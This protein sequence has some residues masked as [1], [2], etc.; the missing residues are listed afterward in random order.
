MKKIRISV[1][2]LAALLLCN[3][4]VTA[5]T[6]KMKPLETAA[7]AYFAD[8]PSSRVVPSAT[9]FKAI[10]AKEKLFLLDIRSA[11]D[12]AKG[13][14]KGAVNAPFGPALTDALAWLPED[15]PVY[16]NCYTGQTAG[17]TIAVLNVAGINAQSIQYGWNL[18]I[19]K[20]EGYEA[21]VT[22]TATPAPEKTGMKIDPSIMTA[23]DA[24][25]KAIP[26]KGNNIWGSDKIK[27]A[28]DAKQDLPIVSVQQAKDYD[29]A[30]IAGSINIP[31][32]KGMQTGF[33]QLP[34][35][36]TFVVHCYTGQTAGQVVGILR[37]LGYDAV[38]MKSGMGNAVTSP[39]GWVNEGYPVVK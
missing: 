39:S 33:A 3:L 8:F 32:V 30:H 9:V 17:Q 12:Y 1:L 2:V 27:A 31:F 26:T 36:K 11:A 28:L 16:V 10:D 4:A 15:M 20:T 13:H 25:F 23:V 38:S 22:T 35:N 5:Q 19:S 18:G 6:A 37:L 24:Y 14:L 7:M 34:K 21:R 29:A